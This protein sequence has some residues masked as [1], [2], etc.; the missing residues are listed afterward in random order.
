MREIWI[1]G[2][3]ID[4]KTLALFV[5]LFAVGCGS[6]AAS[7][8]AQSTGAAQPAPSGT[9]FPKLHIQSKGSATQPVRI[10]QQVGN[11]PVYELIAR[12]SDSTLQSQTNSRG[13]FRQ[14]RITF[15]NND[16]ST[17]SGTAPIATIDTASETVTLEGGVRAK[18]SDGVAFD[19]D[20]VQYDRRSG[21]LL[22]TGNVHVVNPSGEALTGGSFRSD[23]RLSHVHVE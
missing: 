19:C 20:R 22:G 9:P 7:P 23:L 1:G 5:S 16:G 15:Y 13:V 4:R 12:S 17:L 18:S 6:H 2:S 10:I 8:G 14:T 3:V 21:Q 11:R